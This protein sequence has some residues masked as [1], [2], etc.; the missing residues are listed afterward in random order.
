[1]PLE[2]VIIKVPLITDFPPT[3]E[4]KDELE[5]QLMVLAFR[6]GLYAMEFGKRMITDITFIEEGEFGMTEPFP[7]LTWGMLIINFSD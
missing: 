1:M 2:P 5:N 6:H 3:K 4:Q 7:Y